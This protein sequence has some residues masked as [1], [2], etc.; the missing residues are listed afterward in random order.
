MDCVE[1]R[2]NIDLCDNCEFQDLEDY[3]SYA[4]IG[5]MLLIGSFSI[6]VR[7]ID[8]CNKYFYHDISF[9]ILIEVQCRENIECT[10]FER[11][12]C[13]EFRCVRKIN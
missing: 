4:K 6:R 1:S 7:I 12:Y 3:C 13:S 5:L 2:N 8:I 11:P 9:C 10:D